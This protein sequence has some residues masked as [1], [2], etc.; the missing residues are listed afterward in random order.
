MHEQ[1]PRGSFHGKIGH[2][3]AGYRKKALRL[4]WPFVGEGQAPRRAITS[5]GGVVSPKA[6]VLKLH[7]RAPAS[8]AWIFFYRRAVGDE[9]GPGAVR[10]CWE[11]AQRAGLSNRLRKTSGGQQ[12][13]G[14]KNAPRA[15]ALLKLTREPDAV[16]GARLAA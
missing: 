12:A 13:C 6:W 8:F 15:P 3:C 11:G 14:G 16:W 5:T 1:P 10:C 4:G 2:R 7:Q 9:E